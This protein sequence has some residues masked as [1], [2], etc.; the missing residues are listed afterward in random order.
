MLYNFVQVKLYIMLRLFPILL[1]ALTPFTLLF[2]QKQSKWSLAQCLEYSIL[3]NKQENQAVSAG[4]SSFPVYGR[5][6]TS[7]LKPADL[8]TGKSLYS[9]TNPLSGIRGPRNVGGELFPSNNSSKHIPGI[10]SPG[11]FA[12]RSEPAFRLSP[13]PE[14]NAREALSCKVLDAY[15]QILY[16]QDKAEACRRYSEKTE[17]LIRHTTEKSNITK[18]K[19]Q[20]SDERV[21]LENALNQVTL[22]KMI[23]MRIMNLHNTGEF[24]VVRPD[25]AQF[26][27]SR[28]LPDA[29]RIYETALVLRPSLRTASMNDNSPENKTVNK[30]FNYLPSLNAGISSPSANSSEGVSL[31]K[32]DQGIRPTVGVSLS[33]PIWQHKQVRTSNGTSRYGQISKNNADEDVKARLRKGIEQTCLVISLSRSEYESNLQLFRATSASASLSEDKYQQTMTGVEEFLESKN[34]Q[35]KAEAQLLKSKYNLIFSYKMLELYEGVPLSF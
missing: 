5:Q 11:I 18:L 30:E 15:L 10:N 19:S 23:L 20:L 1:L 3:Q 14:E 33:I 27:E 6:T 4:T 25:L 34:N 8:T 17:E 24:N 22:N 32:L 16:A 31:G 21:L 2:P 7:L 12:V 29:S 26:L 13:D 28:K 9:N 35:E